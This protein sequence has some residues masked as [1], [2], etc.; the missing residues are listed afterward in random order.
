MI[1]RD[2][3][4][5]AHAFLKG[6]HRQSRRWQGGR[7]GLS[8]ATGSVSRLSAGVPP[9][10]SSAR[11]RARRRDADRIIVPWLDPSD[12]LVRRPYRRIMRS[13]AFVHRRTWTSVSAG[14]GLGLVH[15]APWPSPT[16]T[17]GFGALRRVSAHVRTDGSIV[18]TKAEA[19]KATAG[20]P[21]LARCRRTP[22]ALVPPISTRA[23]PRRIRTA[24]SAAW[25]ASAS[26]REIAN[27]VPRGRQVGVTAERMPTRWAFPQARR[28]KST[29]R[30]VDP[31]LPGKLNRLILHTSTNSAHPERVKNLPAYLD[32][33]NHF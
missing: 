33:Q 21:S 27:R 14:Q 31:F 12:P 29:D 30:Q 15:R 6:D 10:C 9:A 3:D 1:S 26:I 32:R 7:V 28:T 22:S 2:R 13:P 8:A 25:A 20:S 24:E 23:W 16:L 11:W 17:S 18:P 5:A 19:M 4:I